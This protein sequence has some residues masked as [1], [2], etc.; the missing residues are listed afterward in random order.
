MVGGDSVGEWEWGGTQ[1]V[2]GGEQEAVA[3]VT[4]IGSEEEMAAGDVESGGSGTARVQGIGGC[5]IE[6]ASEQDGAV[7]ALSDID[8]GG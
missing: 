2:F 1:R 7:G 6:G 3:L 5:A 8:K 4:R